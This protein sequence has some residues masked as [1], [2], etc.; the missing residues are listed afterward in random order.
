MWQ[1]RDQSVDRTFIAVCCQR[2]IRASDRE[3]RESCTGGHGMVCSHN[4]E[5]LSC[6]VFFQGGSKKEVNPFSIYINITCT[7]R[8]SL[9]FLI[10]SWCITDDGLKGKMLPVLSTKC[11]WSKWRY[12]GFTTNILLIHRRYTCGRYCLC[13]IGFDFVKISS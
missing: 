8:V 4:C 6:F 11:G 1:F 9:P 13:C 12:M 7:I 3:G 5:G 2:I 10:V